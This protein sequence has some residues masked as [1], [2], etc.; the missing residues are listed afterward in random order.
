MKTKSVFLLGAAL[1]FTTALWAQGPSTPA[2]GAPTTSWSK[3]GTRASTE[4]AIV[5]LSTL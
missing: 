2:Q 3:K 5:I 4:W 1:L